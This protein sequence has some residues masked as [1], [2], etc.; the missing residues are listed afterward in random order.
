MPKLQQSYKINEN[1]S[2]RVAKK[3]TGKKIPPKSTNLKYL[4][5]KSRRRTLQKKSQK[6]KK[7]HKRLE[8][9][10]NYMCR[11]DSQQGVEMKLSVK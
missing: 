3:R 4:T 7:V 9:Y 10:E 6:H 11:L 1:Y 2:A 5:P 8:K